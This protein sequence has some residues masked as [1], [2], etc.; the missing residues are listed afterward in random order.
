VTVD[1]D[2]HFTSAGA[3]DGGMPVPVMT[4]GLIPVDRWLS[5]EA[6]A[7]LVAKDPRTTR[8]TVFHGPG[9]AR[10]CIDDSEESWIAAGTFEASVGAGET[11]GAEEWVATPL[12]LLRYEAAKASVTVPQAPTAQEG[13]KVAAGTAYVWVAEDARATPVMGM[14]AGDGGRGAGGA[15]SASDEGWTRIGEGQ[16]LSVAAMAS[17][18]AGHAGVTSLAFAERAVTKCGALAEASRELASLVLH[19]AADAA[20]IASQVTTRRL[21]HA[22]CS[23]A[24]VRAGALPETEETATLLASLRTATAA[25]ANLPP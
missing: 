18:A 5:L 8:E 3:A 11:P 23:V 15:P 4:Q 2:V 9:R 25:Y 17:P 22:A 1:G 12:L 19:G 13:V 14:V 7:R 21:A 6:G 16:S 20:A 10:A 24:S